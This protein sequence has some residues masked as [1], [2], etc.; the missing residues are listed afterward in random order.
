MSF[1]PPRPPAQTKHERLCPSEIRHT[2]HAPIPGGQTPATAQ[3]G[4]ERRGHTNSIG[5]PEGCK[6]RGRAQSVNAMAGLDGE[7]AA[8]SCQT[9]T[10][11]LAHAVHTCRRDHCSSGT[12]LRQAGPD[13]SPGTRR[14]HM[15]EGTLQ[16]WQ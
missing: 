16:Q 1:G 12:D 7:A 3:H 8:Q 11:F 5:E 10:R 15:Q 4:L 9:P 14:A 2:G 13:Q 6:C